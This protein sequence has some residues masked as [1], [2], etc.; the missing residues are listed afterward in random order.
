MDTFGSQHYG[1][2]HLYRNGTYVGCEGEMSLMVNCVAG[3]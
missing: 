2:P 3:F 1:V